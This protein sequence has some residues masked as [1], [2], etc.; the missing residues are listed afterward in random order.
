MALNTSKATRETSKCIYVENSFH[1]EFVG[2]AKLLI[3]KLGNYILRDFLQRK[4]V[5]FPRKLQLFVYCVQSN[6]TRW[7]FQ[8]CEDELQ[9]VTFWL[10]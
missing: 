10:A 9:R 5:R 6:Y 7:Y 2:C 3:A 1:I 8:R 4:I